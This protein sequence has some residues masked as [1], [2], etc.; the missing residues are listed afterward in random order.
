MVL[1]HQLYASMGSTF[2]SIPDPSYWPRYARPVLLPNS[3]IRRSTKG[4][5]KSTRLDNEMYFKEGGGTIKCDKC[6]DI[7]QNRRLCHKNQVQG[8]L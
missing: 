6:E 2:W 7:G 5:P 3:G 4:R 8:R 1:Q